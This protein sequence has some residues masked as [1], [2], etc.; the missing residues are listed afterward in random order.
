[1]RF[2]PLAIHGFNVGVVRKGRNCRCFFFLKAPVVRPGL[3][4][5]PIEGEH[6]LVEL[7]SIQ[8]YVMSITGQSE[9]NGVVLFDN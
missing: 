6:I 2:M 7:G 8:N 3:F 9:G 1:M 4:Q 5:H